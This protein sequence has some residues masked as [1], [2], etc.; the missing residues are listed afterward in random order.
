MRQL[1]QKDV[2]DIH[3]AYAVKR[4]PALLTEIDQHLET[5]HIPEL[6]KLLEELSSTSQTARALWKGFNEAE[7]SPSAADA[8]QPSTSA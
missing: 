1:V 7:P 5:V 8:N 4:I 3:T 6:L 2:R